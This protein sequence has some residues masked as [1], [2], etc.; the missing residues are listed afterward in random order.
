MMLETYA[1]SVAG[2]RTN[3]EDAICAH[4]ELGL[5]VIADG[6]GG[7]EGGEIASALA[8]EAIPEE[9]RSARIRP[10]RRPGAPCTDVPRGPRQKRGSG[11][12]DDH[13]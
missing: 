13:G 7:Y 4:P 1:L 5:F 10:S 8:I 3:N 9:R 2:R 11:Q 12:K 6:I